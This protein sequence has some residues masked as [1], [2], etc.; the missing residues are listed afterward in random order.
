MRDFLDQSDHVQALELARHGR[1]CEWHML[2]EIGTPP[3][4]DVEFAALHGLEQR[5]VNAVEEV[6]PLDR[7]I[8]AHAGL[9][10]PLQITLARAG[11]VQAG[12]E[13]EVALV[14]AQQDLAQIDQAE[15]STSS[16]APTRAWPNGLCV[17]PCGGA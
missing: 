13:R 8:A 14:A 16:A 3:A 15:E 5:L 2:D 6:Q 10:Q 1:G 12:Q 17:P 11:V 4:V 9:A 7:R